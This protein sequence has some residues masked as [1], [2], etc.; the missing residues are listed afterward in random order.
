M[1]PTQE[2]IEEQ[3][4]MICEGTPNHL[5]AWEEMSKLVMRRLRSS[6]P[7]VRRVM[8]DLA[9]RGAVKEVK[10][11]PAGYLALSEEDEA[12]LAT[13]VYLE[14]EKYYG[15]GRGVVQIDKDYR[16]A[17]WAGS[18]YR[19]YVTHQRMWGPLHASLCDRIAAKR[20]E[21]KEEREVEG[22][23]REVFLEERVPSYAEARKALG[24]LFP[25][26]EMRA[27]VH[28]SD[29]KDPRV[30]VTLEGVHLSEFTRLMDIIRH[31]LKN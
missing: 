28:R 7:H 23:L 14:P 6:T 16:G 17:L 30:Y 21:K 13:L 26:M 8:R 31:G 9:A 22:L 10:V 27:V 25:C 15:I 12:G 5:Y 1:A 29:I 24:A 11:A 19:A 18:D 3:I 20:A 2:Q 4:L